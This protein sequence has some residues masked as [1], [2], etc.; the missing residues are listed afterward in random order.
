MTAIIQAYSNLSKLPQLAEELY[1]LGVLRYHV[2][3]SGGYLKKQD[4]AMKL[5][6]FAAFAWG[7]LAYN[8]L[9]ILWGAYVRATGSG[10][11]CGSHWPSCQGQVIPWSSQA[12]TIIEFTH[13]LT[14]GLALIL[15]IG[16]L[17]WAYRAYPKGHAVRLGAKLAMFFMVV[18]AMV[19]AGLVLFELVAE[20]TSIARAVVS[21]GHLVNT[22]LLMGSL[23]LTA[24]WA[25]GGQPIQLRTQGWLG[26]ALGAG[27]LGM[28]LLGASGGVTALGDTLFPASSLAEGLQQKYSP[29]AHF[30]VRLRLFHPL[31]AV[32]IGAYIIL[33]AGI[34]FNALRPTQKTTRRIAKIFTILYLVQLG[35]G[36]FN[37]A[38]LAPIWLQLVHLLLSD[39]ILIALVLFI[40][41]A[42]AQQAPQAEPV[43]LSRKEVY[44]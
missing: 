18:E 44:V 17:V 6:R 8:I 13:R 29:T 22:F 37:V 27:F 42:F 43:E 24:W 35:V 41:A 23:T 34:L 26:W 14:S 11:G 31:L 30:L 25:S 1:T 9:V 16:L 7:V 21:A 20:D 39:L 12:E 38:L 19:G 3:N 4:P 36:A 2:Y 15:V 5:N 33:M 40:A 28:L 32:G 10:A